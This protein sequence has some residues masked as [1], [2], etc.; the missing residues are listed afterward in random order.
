MK[1]PIVL[2]S[3][4]AMVSAMLS[5]AE[6]EPLVVDAFD[7]KLEQGW[8]WLREERGAWRFR[9]GA[10]EIRVQPGVADNVKNALVRDVPDRSRG[11]YAFEVT[12]T[13][14]APPTRQYEQAGIT[15]YHD[16]KPFAKL[17]KEYIDGKTWI[18]LAGPT[19]PDGKR[20]LAGKIPMESQTVR[21]RLVVTADRYQGQFQPGAEGPFQPAG[22]GP[23]P[24]PSGDQVSIQCYNG[25]PEAEHW[26]RF[27]D[28]RAME[29]SE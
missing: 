23:L 18:V 17:V 6:P 19:D 25:P 10:L 3:L 29:L 7:G 16:G 26:F 12:V 9:D 22:A 1:R 24:P 27:D 4:V 13:S 5:A 15:W 2:A 8:S 21:L 11:K 14:T 28:F 20:G